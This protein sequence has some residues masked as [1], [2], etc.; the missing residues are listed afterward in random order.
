MERLNLPV[1]PKGTNVN[2]PL[3]LLKGEGSDTGT[4]LALWGKHG[5]GN[6]ILQHDRRQQITSHVLRLRVFYL[7]SDIRGRLVFL[8]TCIEPMNYRPTE[9]TRTASPEYAYFFQHQETVVFAK[10][11]IVSIMTRITPGVAQ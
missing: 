7:V 4:S 8:L 6:G 2:C 10:E 3:G 5:S 1:T 11:S 9:E